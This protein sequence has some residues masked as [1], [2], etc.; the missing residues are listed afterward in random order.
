MDAKRSRTR[1]AAVVLVAIIVWAN[2]S[3][4]RAEDPQSGG[5][6]EL[7][8]R[9]KTKD[10]DKPRE[11]VRGPSVHPASKLAAWFDGHIR[12]RDGRQ[13]RVPLVLKRGDVGFS[14][15][16]ARIGA[17]ADAIEVYANDSALG[18][19]LADR[20]RTHCKGRPTCAVWVEGKIARDEEGQSRFDVMRVS[21]PIKPH[22]L[23]A[24]NY[25]EVEELNI[26]EPGDPDQG[27]PVPQGARRNDSLGGATSLASGRNYTLKVYEIDS[28]I[29]AIIAFYERH[30][31]EAKRSAEGQEVSFSTPRGSVK[32]ARVFKATRITLAIGP[33]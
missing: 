12:R 16:G 9:M 20:A 15:R 13:L 32:L 29:A 28:D 2:G 30:L 18:I 8:A 31:P 11:F 3:A 21:A 1:H 22:A 5:D 4:P 19:G 17:A 7:K 14:L 24:A 10:S 26:P 25:I 27:F 33:R 23:A 6:T